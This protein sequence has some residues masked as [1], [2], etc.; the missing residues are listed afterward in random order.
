MLVMLLACANAGNLIL[1]RGLSRQRELAIRLSLGASRW[2]VTRQLLTEALHNLLCRPSRDQA[3]R[4]RA[5]GL[6]TF[7]RE[8]GRPT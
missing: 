2:R 8:P 4:E 7:P 6:W 3:S 1:A 5:R